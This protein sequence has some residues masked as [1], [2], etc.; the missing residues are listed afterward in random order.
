MKRIVS[1]IDVSVI[2]FIVVGVINTLVGTL[3]MFS[4]Y[5]II[6]L[7]Y[8]ISTSANYI[9]GS[10]LSYFLNKYW[11][12]QHKEKSIKIILKFVVNII[13]CYF[14]AYSLAKYLVNLVLSQFN[15]NIQDNVSMIIGL[16]LFTVLNYS[17]QKYFAF[18]KNE[19]TE[20][21]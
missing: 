4:C 21:V 7:N 17:G 11:T 1:L 14:L 6:G 15:N 19:G 20:V 16:I 3:I 8:W 13:I 5:N 9:V 12:F 18:K 10:V 2:K